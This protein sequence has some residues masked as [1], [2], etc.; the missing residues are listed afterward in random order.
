MI[1]FKQFL[2]ES[3]NATKQWGTVRATKAD[4]EA[5]L[6]FV[7]DHSRLPL[8]L[9]KDNL[10]GSTELTLLDKKQDSGDIDVA[11]KKTDYSFE[12]LDT[13]L[14]KAVNDERK[15]S[16]GTQV[17]S[18]AVPV[19][20]GK[21]VQF[22]LMFVNSNDWAKFAYYSGEG[23]TSKY[24]GAVRNILL[25]TVA[26]YKQVPGEDF[27]ALD[28][29]GDLLARASR[30][31]KM[32]TGLERLFKITKTGPRGGKKEEKVSPKELKDYLI[33]LDPKYKS[34]KFAEKADVI[35][36]PDEVAKHL[37]GSSIK[38]KDIMTVEQVLALIAD[39]KYVSASEK[40]KIIDDAKEA[41]AK[42]GMDLPP[43]LK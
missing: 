19:G 5:A 16:S 38:A 24:K 32:D 27:V 34:V 20:K 33:D 42:T 18:Y 30:S 17:A 15:W 35:D 25:A 43:E 10:L 12:D 7:A 37:F 29:N 11:I 21:K 9:L 23:H 6:K 13:E 3:G 39:P 41:L 22:D 4:I 8:K 28:D 31:W 36:D 1:T 26:R 40:T 2:F 14:A